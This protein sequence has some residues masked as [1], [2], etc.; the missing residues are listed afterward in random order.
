MKKIITRLLILLLLAGAA[1]CWLF[2]APA[3]SFE[4]KSKYFIIAEDKKDKASI[5]EE[6]KNNEIISGKTGFSLVASA[7]GVWSRIRPGKYEVKKGE[8]LLD[9]ARMLKNGR[10]A[11]IKLVINRVRTK[12]NL[13]RLISK[14][15][16]P[17]SVAVMQYL[18]SNDSLKKFGVDTN[19]VFTMIMQDTYI[20]YWNT[21][22]DKIFRRLYDAGN[23]FWQKNQRLEKAASLN[24]EK[25]QV[26]ILA[27]IIDEETNYDSDKA[28][29]ASV[30]MNRLNLGMPLQADPT[31]KFAMKDFTLTRIYLRYLDNPSPYNTYR[32]KGLPPGPICTP[33]PKTIDIILDAPKTDYLFFVA[34]SDFSGY[35]HFSS[36][37]TEH[38]QYAKEYQKALDEYMARKQQNQPKP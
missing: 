32:R 2:L 24:L 33:S 11:Q 10:L 31:I 3:T 13:A 17:D 16:K 21:P 34:K 12:E 37:Y 20:F 25:E 28:P 15:F 35:H 5:L 18:T 23:A 6:M 27:S 22:L 19:T 29:I 36:S 9:I 8:S 4:G 26:Y 1:A 38:T 30:Y 14:N 7:L